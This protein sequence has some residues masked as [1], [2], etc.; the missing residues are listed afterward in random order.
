M[1]ATPSSSRKPRNLTDGASTGGRSCR[2]TANFGTDYTSRGRGRPCRPG[3]EPPDDAIYPHAMVDSDGQPLNGAN[4]YPIRF[5]KGQL[6]PVKAFWSITMYNEKQAFIQN[7]IS[8]YAIG[9]RDQLK[10]DP[11]GSLT[12]YF[13]KDSPGK[14]KESNWLPTPEGLVQSVHAPV[15]AGARPLSTAPGSASGRA[16]EAVARASTTA[17]VRKST[18]AYDRCRPEADIAHLLALSRVFPEAGPGQR[19]PRPPC[20]YSGSPP[21]KANVVPKKSVRFRRYLSAIYR[22]IVSRRASE[23]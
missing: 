6:P 15:L 12:L 14:D 5:P 1:P 8:R 3:C 22:S 17:S 19:R 16:G 20:G 23:S 18:S 4:R 10:F 2:P 7:P 21:T 13:Q 9:D 11:D